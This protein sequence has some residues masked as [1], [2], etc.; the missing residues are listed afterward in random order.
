MAKSYHGY[1]KTG[2]TKTDILA[3]KLNAN[4]EVVFNELKEEHVKKG[5]I[6]MTI[7]NIDYSKIHV[8]DYVKVLKYQNGKYKFLSGGNLSVKNDTYIK[9]KPVHLPFAFS[10]QWKDIHSIFVRYSG[11]TKNVLLKL[12]AQNPTPE[13]EKPK[14]PM[15]N[16]SGQKLTLP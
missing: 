9:L 5:Y 16:L 4:F 15:P 10:V 14:L 8:S 13:D 2:K 11:Y 6:I 1:T 12:E 3:D 7:P